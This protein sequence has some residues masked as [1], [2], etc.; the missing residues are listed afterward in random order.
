MCCFGEPAKKRLGFFVEIPKRKK[1]GLFFFW[2]GGGGSDKGWECTTPSFGG[3]WEFKDDAFF[4]PNVMVFFHES[5]NNGCVAL[6]FCGLSLAKSGSVQKTINCFFVVRVPS[7]QKPRKGLKFEKADAK[8]VD[9]PSLKLSYRGAIAPENRGWKMS[10]FS[11]RFP[12]CCGELLTLMGSIPVHFFV[13]EGVGLPTSVKVMYF[14]IRV[15]IFLGS[16]HREKV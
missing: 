5:K 1:S 9:V 13:L 8:I 2:G 7:P 3:F 6:V 10:L 4:F 15:V 12:L 14:S 11:G 16:F